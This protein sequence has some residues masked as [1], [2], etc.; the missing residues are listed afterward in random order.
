MAGDTD[1]GEK[2]QEP[3]QKR[4]DDARAKGQVANAPEMRHVTV[5]LGAIILVAMVG[6]MTIARLGTLCLRLWGNADGY[7]MNPMG[8]QNFATGVMGATGLALAPIA[9][10]FVGAAILSIFLQGRPTMSW[11]RVSFK[12]SKL[13]PI[14]GFGRMF[15]KRALV[16]FAKTVAK[17]VV[18]ITVALWIVWPRAIAFDQM[19][20]ASPLA[21]AGT[22][23]ELVLRMVKAVAMLVVALAAFDFV[24]QRRAFMQKMRMTLQELKDEIK[25]SEGDPK[26]K[27]RVRQIQ[28]RRARQ[29]M[30][31]AVPTASVI[32]TN[33]T[34]YSV[35]LKYEHGAMAAPVVVAKGV[36]EVAMRIREIAKGANVPIVESPPLARALYAAVEI[37]RPIPVEHYAAVAEI[38]GY[39]MR[40][41]R[42]IA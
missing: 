34:H 21:I 31:Q 35:A 30:M 33:P 7:R 24:Y 5:F 29:R 17:F 16:E 18:V 39:V 37:D 2:T 15:G 12:W 22:A 1:N 23:T 10:L 20:G 26:I 11:S 14:S 25:Q 4:L 13:S 38:I 40:L 6:A 9:G 36:D 19:I 8:A 42:R 3:T 28:M 41:A 32:I 27:A